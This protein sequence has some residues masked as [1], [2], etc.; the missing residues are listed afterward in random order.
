MHLKRF[1]I[2]M[3]LLLVVLYSGGSYADDDFSTLVIFSDSLSD[4]GNL[5]SVQG[6][7][8]FPFFMNR[9]SNG[10]IMVDI[11]A[12]L[13]GLTAAPSL[14]L[15]G[16]RPRGTISQWRPPRPAARGALI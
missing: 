12:D 4:T 7:F 10:P 13:L 11:L 16:T 6:D 9:V 14:H 8:P 5:A 2:I 15:T 1:S 3:A